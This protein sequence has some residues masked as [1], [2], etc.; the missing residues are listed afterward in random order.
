[1]FRVSCIIKCKW[2]NEELPTCLWQPLARI[3]TFLFDRK[4]SGG[5][6]I[7]TPI[8]LIDFFSSLIR[9]IGWN[10]YYLYWE[11]EQNRAA[12]VLS[13][14]TYL[15]KDTGQRSLCL[16]DFR[17]YPVDG[18]GDYLTS[19]VQ[20][21]FCSKFRALSTFSPQEAQELEPEKQGKGSTILHPGERSV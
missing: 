15:N 8:C 4:L 5:S 6:S 11:H 13:R 2:L 19:V 17:G 12:E 20:R 1:M 3:R 14:L 18:R 9:K 10:Y 7:T 21:Y 16:G